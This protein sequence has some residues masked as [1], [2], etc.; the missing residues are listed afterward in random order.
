M[1][2]TPRVRAR[3]IA[4]RGGATVP[5]WWRDAKL[6]IFVHWTPAS[7]PGW[8]PT[9]LEIGELLASGRANALAET[10]Y[11]EWYE[12]SL[13]FPGSSV[14]Q[15]H[16]D[17][18]AGRPYAEF[19][20]LF[21]AGLNAWDPEDWARRF[22]AA[23]ARY[24]VLVSKHHD[25]FCLWPTGVANPQ[26]R[27]WNTS[28]DVV[29]ELAEAV[30]GQ[31]LR[32]GLYYSG[33]LDWTFN[34][35]PIGRP[36]DLLA[37]VPTGG[38]GDYADAH[39]RELVD[40]Y[41]PDLLWGDIAWP[42]NRRRLAELIGHYRSL[43]PDGVVN[44]RFMPHSVLSGALTSRPAAALIDRGA[45]WMAKR[46]RGIVPPKPTIYDTRSPEY[47]IFD[48]TRHG[49]WECVRGIDRSFGFNQNSDD[50]HFIGRDELLWSVCD[51]VAKG[52]NLLLNVG[53]RGVDA[54]IPDAQLTRLDWLADFLGPDGDADGV[55][56]TRPWIA[57]GGRCDD[58]DV[59]YW[60][61]RGA[62][63]AAVRAGSASGA[64][65]LDGLRPTAATK[66]ELLGG[67]QAQV[68]EHAGR[69]RVTWSGAAER[70]VTLLRI[71]AATA[72]P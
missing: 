2:R 38:Y 64:T 62:V 1:G 59:R 35:H 21:Q 54:Q 29:G 65:T 49:A 36:S 57:P 45:T 25:G 10:P 32:F 48:D 56:G 26:R 11:T 22:R 61:D 20:D 17:V 51:I 30:R 3:P 47:A 58:T 6:G 19:G 27:G 9:E 60:V 41:R 55:R 14:S 63:V 40:R 42:G 43:V 31:G 67:G 72:A 69:L 24:V 70:P 37:A 15:H 33:G 68:A 12:N 28:R 4:D 53:P 52:G 18:H 5:A 8:A 50:S 16:A 71:H 44:D 46:D 66:A 23:G 7:V 13:R 34:D 39:V